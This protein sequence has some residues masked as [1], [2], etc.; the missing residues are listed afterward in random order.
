MIYGESCFLKD[1][2]YSVSDSGCIYC[3]REC[4][5]FLFMR[6][7]FCEMP[8]SLKIPIIFELWWDFSGFEDND[9][10][11]GGIKVSIRGPIF[12]TGRIHGKDNMSLRRWDWRG[13]G[14]VCD[15]CCCR[16]E[17]GILRFSPSV[18]VL[19]LSRG[20]RAGIID[21]SSN[22]WVNEGIIICRDFDMTG[23]FLS[24]VI[25]D[26]SFRYVDN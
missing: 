20:F 18:K 2:R 6:G 3:G 5:I 24:R 19:T 9:L 21:L 8:L 25:V 17:L 15:G 13:V 16:V 23:C 11:V 4:L 22:L 26:V 14:G 7:K 12:L 10:I 1:N